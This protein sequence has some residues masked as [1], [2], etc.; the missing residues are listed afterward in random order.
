MA[1]DKEIENLQY[2]IHKMEG[3]S[4]GGNIG[5]RLYGLGKVGMQLFLYYI[6]DQNP[7]SFLYLP[8]AVDGAA[9][10][11]TGKHHTLMFRILR[12]H[13][14]YKLEKLLVKQQKEN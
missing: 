8:L 7:L 13:P 6:T 10:L 14:K 12:A 2:Q 4:L 9:D 5:N 1:I 11:L 3:R